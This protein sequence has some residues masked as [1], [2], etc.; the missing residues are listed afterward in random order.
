[1]IQE[2][3]LEYDLPIFETTSSSIYLRTNNP[4]LFGRRFS[5]INKQATTLV[6]RVS[7]KWVTYKPYWCRSITTRLF[8]SKICVS[9][10]TFSYDIKYC[11]TRE[12][13]VQNYN[14]IL[15]VHNVNR[16]NLICFLIQSRHHN[17]VIMSPSLSNST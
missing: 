11:L 12:S 9:E 7:R 3:R 1:M 8:S 13:K 6:R 2:N 4:Y 10:R 15:P 16:L 17:K 14:A 5:S